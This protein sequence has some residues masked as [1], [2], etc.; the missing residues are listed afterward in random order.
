MDL[1]NLLTDLDA[2]AFDYRKFAS[3]A[4]YSVAQ[5]YR[6]AAKAGLDH[7]MSARRRVLLERAAWHIT[8]SKLTVSVLALDA[9]FDSTDGFSRAFAR[10]FG[11]KPTVFRKLAPQEYRIGKRTGIHSAPGKYH[12]NRQGETMTFIQR[13]LDTHCTEMIKI[14]DALESH[15]E[16][17]GK[18][19]PL[20]NPFPWDWAPDDE[21]V[22][23]LM[24]RACS[25]ATPWLHAIQG[26]KDNPDFTNKERVISQH[27]AFS[28]FV[29]DVEREGSWEVT[30][31]DADCTPPE[32]FSYAS[33]IHHVITFNEHA[34][35]TLIQ[36][37]RA[38][39]LGPL[40]PLPAQV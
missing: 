2:E 20:T 3:N 35:I 29:A 17:S 16:L 32:V 31:I 4:G 21:T 27:E 40:D 8:R 24:A 28:Q 11:V 19:L 15:P 5:S 23:E 30:F 38:L 12:V 10:A 14:V 6:L 33:V 9:G 25:G 34:R 1:T 36:R 7:P 39:G 13:I 26:Y 22:A 37:L 18:L